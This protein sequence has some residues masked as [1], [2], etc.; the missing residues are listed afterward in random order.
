MTDAAEI[1]RALR[2]DGRLPGAGAGAGASQPPR[3]EHRVQ[4]F[5]KGTQSRHDAPG[6]AGGAGRAAGAGAADDGGRR[7]GQRVVRAA[8]EGM[9]ADPAE[10]RPSTRDRHGVKQRISITSANTARRSAVARAA[11]SSSS[12]A[13]DA[14][15][16]RTASRAS[17]WSSPARS[18]RRGTSTAA[19]RTVTVEMIVEWRCSV[20]CVMW[21]PSIWPNG[22]RF[23]AVASMPE[24]GREHHRVRVERLAV[25]DR[26]EDQ[27]ATARK[28]SGSPNSSPCC[29]VR[30]RDDCDS[31]TPQ[32]STGT[33]ITKPAIG[34]ATPMSNST[35]PGRERLPDP[36]DRAKRAGRAS[37]AAG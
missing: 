29:D 21:P 31:A 20:A 28:S 12:T 30:R 13:G 36:D 4:L 33:S 32:N 27:P 1:V 5:L 8:C 23:S 14:D 22:S 26:A 7:S 18:V 24:P 34:P 15:R 6:A 11:S 10:R 9:S 2:T 17:R 19:P 16:P 37:A 25:R 35:R 3:G